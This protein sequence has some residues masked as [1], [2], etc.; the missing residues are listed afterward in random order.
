M[1]VICGECG[2]KYRIDTTIIKGEQAGFVCKNCNHPIAVVKSEAEEETKI[3]KPSVSGKGP[4]LRPK[5]IFLFAFLPVLLMAVPSQLYLYHLDKLSSFVKEE[6]SR[7][8]TELTEEAITQN[9]RAVALQIRLYLL[10]HPELKK[11]DF[12][13]DEDFKSV[14]VQKIGLS[15]YT[16]LYEL[17]DREG[18]WHI[19][20]HPDP[21]FVGIDMS[22][23]KKPLDK[24]LP[25]FWKIYSGVKEGKEA[26]GYYAWQDADG[27]F[28]D[29]YMVCTPVV[30][31]SYIIAGTIYIEE[32]S[33]LLKNIEN[34]REKAREDTAKIIIIILAGPLVLIGLIVTLFSQVLAGRIK[35]LT[36]VAGRISEGELDV[37]IDIKSKDEI[38][39]LGDAIARMQD[40]IRLSIERL[41]RRR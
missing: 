28:R 23:L 3:A 11:E 12:N 25:G 6:N 4:G 32:Y 38:G 1:I 19:W 35:H 18:I 27:D 7:V 17:P 13:N 34:L 37:K 41:R 39:A 16:A 29:K 15:G 8:I 24:K 30:G 33:L 36:D 9:A 20:A 14:A 31:T 10:D 2:K 22:K 26:K 21:E 5:M 40:S